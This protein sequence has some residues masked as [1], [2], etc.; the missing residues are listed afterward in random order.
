MGVL[1][2]SALGSLLFLVYIDDFQN[3]MSNV[4]RLFADGSAVVVNA[5]F[6]QNLK[7]L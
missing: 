7:I 3:C 1:Q 2:G 4:P 6:L 5:D